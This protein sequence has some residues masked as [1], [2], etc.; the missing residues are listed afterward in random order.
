[1]QT[2]QRYILYADDDPDDQDLM[3]EVMQTTGSGISVIGVQNGLEVMRFLANLQKGDH[4]PVM[5]VLDINM[6]IAGGYQTLKMLKLSPAYAHIPVTIFST[7]SVD[8]EH[9]KA[10][11]FGAHGFITKPLYYRELLQVC[12]NIADFCKEEASMIK[13]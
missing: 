6:P 10:K 12:K 8:D 2:N 5:I 1:M 3:L 9:K 13:T 4:F 11:R 7:T